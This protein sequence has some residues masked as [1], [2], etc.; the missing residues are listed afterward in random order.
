[1]KVVYIIDT[2]NGYGAEKSIVQIAIS[3][4]K[5]TPV[6]VQLYKG[7]FLVELLVMNSIKVYSLKLAN[8]SNNG[9]EKIISII[10]LEKPDIIHST[11]FRS[12]QMCKK[13]EKNL[14]I[15]N[16]SWKFCK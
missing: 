12:D 13:I 10:K 14:S 3:L 6:F 16:F 1:M 11:L 5:T 2:L 15:D 8:G 4:N 9:L 7:D